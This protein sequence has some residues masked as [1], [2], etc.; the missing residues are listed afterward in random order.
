MRPHHDRD[1]PARS[2]AAP[3]PA[4]PRYPWLRDRRHRRSALRDVGRA[5]RRGWPIP[6]EGRAALVAE[7]LALL[8][9]GELS[10]RE[11][12]AVSRIFLAM[13]RANEDRG[14]DDGIVPPPGA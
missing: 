6:P 2:G 1:A 5:V 7:L 10:A 3:G 13:D 4:A 12:L 11:T 8:D 14:P 9:S